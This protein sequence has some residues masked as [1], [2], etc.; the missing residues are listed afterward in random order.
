M[1]TQ[2]NKMKINTSTMFKNEIGEV[3][4]KKNTEGKTKSIPPFDGNPK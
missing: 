4:K 3:K 2:K 1:K